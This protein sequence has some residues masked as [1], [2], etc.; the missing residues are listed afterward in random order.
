MPVPA[1]EP[2]CHEIQALWEQTRVLNAGKVADYIP[3]LAKAPPEAYGLGLC[4]IAGERFSLGD[5]QTPFSLQSVCKPGNYGL[6][7][8]TLGEEQVHRHVGREPSGMVFNELRLNQRGLP[9]NPLINAGAI[10]VCALIHADLSQPE[11]FER[12]SQTWQHLTG[13]VRPGFNN[14]VYLSERQHADRNFALA[15]FMRENGAF[16]VGTDLLAT[17][18]FYFQCCSLE[19]DVRAL[20]VAAAT[21]ANGGVCPLTGEVVFQPRTVRHMLSL[22]ASCGLYDFSGEFAF[23]VGL[24]AKSGVSGGLMLVVPGVMGMA[25][26]SPPLDGHGNSVRSV[27]FCEQLVARYPLHRYDVLPRA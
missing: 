20:S 3:Q 12:V 5:D 18:D 23:R 26:W 11:R 24:P 10:M 9:H 8:E 13:G 14:A 25:L 27:A 4:T 7:L 1:F 22:M 2:L 17:L 15:Y 19:L 16:P 21:L 6:V